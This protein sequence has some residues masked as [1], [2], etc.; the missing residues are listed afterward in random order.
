MPDVVWARF[1]E[2]VV[3]VI[4]AIVVVVVDLENHSFKRTWIQKSMKCQ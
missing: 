4:V 1:V 2:V 3:L